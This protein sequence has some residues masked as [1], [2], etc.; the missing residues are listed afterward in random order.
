MHHCLGLVIA[1]N[2]SISWHAGVVELGYTRAACPAGVQFL[3]SPL[4]SWCE[5]C[6]R[7]GSDF[8]PRPPPFPPAPPSSPPSPPSRPPL[9]LAFPSPPPPPPSPPPAPPAPPCSPPRGPPPPPSPPSPPPPLLPGD[10]CEDCDV[11]YGGGEFRC[12]DDALA[13]FGARYTCDTLEADFALD[14]AGCRC[15]AAPPAAPP[16]NAPPGEPPDEQPARSAFLTAAA[17]GLTFT[18]ALS[19]LCIALTRGA[20]RRS[21]DVWVRIPDAAAL[22]GALRIREADVVDAVRRAATPKGVAHTKP[23]FTDGERV[24]VVLDGSVWVRVLDDRSGNAA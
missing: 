11:S 8:R 17:A 18:S 24:Y 5:F 13:V 10:V 22:H 14:C 19:C 20:R 1:Y 9:V 21:R 2:C 4:W 7:A 15:R 16:P 3:H 12:C 6:Q 23:F